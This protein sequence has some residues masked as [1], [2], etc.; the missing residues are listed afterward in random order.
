MLV[1][2]HDGRLMRFNGSTK[3]ILGASDSIL[4]SQTCAEWLPHNEI[5]TWTMQ[6]V[7]EG[8]NSGYSK[9]SN[10]DYRSVRKRVSSV[11]G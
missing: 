3:A 8:T 1:C 2:R 10:T 4:R 11:A 9:C 5:F 7:R 6:E